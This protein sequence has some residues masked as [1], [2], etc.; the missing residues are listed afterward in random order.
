VEKRTEDFLVFPRLWRGK[1]NIN[2]CNLPT[3]LS[4][5]LEAQP[6]SAFLL[7]F[8]EAKFTK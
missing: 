6:L 3:P 2:Q 8:G 7:L 5:F 1:T 4:G